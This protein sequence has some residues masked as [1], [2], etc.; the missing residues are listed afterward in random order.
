MPSDVPQN[1]ESWGSPLLSQLQTLDSM[2]SVHYYH[3]F[4]VHYYHRM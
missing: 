1:L 4:S 2:F 3:W